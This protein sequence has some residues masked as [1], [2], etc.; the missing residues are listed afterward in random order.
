[1]VWGKT[2]A[3]CPADFD[4]EAVVRCLD[5]CN[6]ELAPKIAACRAGSHLFEYNMSMKPY[7]KKALHANIKL[8]GTMLQMNDTGVFKKSVIN[9][10]LAVWNDH[11]GNVLTTNRSSE[12][13]SDQGYVLQ[14]MILTVKDIK[15]GCSTG[16]RLPSWL[17]DLIDLLPVTVPESSNAM[18]PLEN[19]PSTSSVSFAQQPPAKEKKKFILRRVSSCGSSTSATETVVYPEMLGTEE[20][21]EALGMGVVHKMVKGEAVAMYPDGKVATATSHVSMGNGF[22]KFY[23]ED[24]SEWA[25]T[26]PALSLTPSQ[27]MKKPAACNKR[28]AAEVPVDG[29]KAF[30]SSEAHR[31]YSKAYHKAKSAYIKQCKVDGVEADM[32]VARERG[33]T[34]AQAAV[35]MD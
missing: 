27:P 8:L 19:M 26:I 1:M 21:P 12:Y 15:K 5:A 24:G 17:K 32:G 28:P 2:R 29:G 7:D 4:A 25:S 18:V 10:G 14:H 30:K 11:N 34:A 13:L 23:F 22:A 16:S 20:D 3:K 6:D 33:K 31:S 9:A 35:S